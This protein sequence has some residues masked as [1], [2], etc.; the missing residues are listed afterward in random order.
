MWFGFLFELLDDYYPAPTPPSSS[1]TS[2][3]GLIGTG[4][5]ARELTGWGTST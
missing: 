4:R 3:A 2:R 1:S 5:G